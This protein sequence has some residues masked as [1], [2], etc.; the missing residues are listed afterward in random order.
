MKKTIIT[1]VVAL[2]ASV[3]VCAQDNGRTPKPGKDR[4]PAPEKM[5]EKRIKQMTRELNLTDEQQAKVREILTDEI[6]YENQ[7]RQ[8]VMKCKK[9]NAERIDQLLTPEQ[10]AKRDE[11]RKQAKKERG[12]DK[13]DCCDEGKGKPSCDEGKDPAALSK[14]DDKKC[15]ASAQKCQANQQAC[16][17][18]KADCLKADSKACQADK[19][20][21]QA[22][23][24]ACQAEKKAC[25]ADKKACQA[26][27]K[28]CKGEKADCCQA[29]KKA[30][31]GDCK[32]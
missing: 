6:N 10:K 26:E 30:C 11:T 2:F 12:K 3:A 21:C 28:D 19:K 24:K 17:A 22:D 9:Q 27:K 29:E 23:K 15:Q 25:Q 13:A 1:L 18:E 7:V 14:A 4:G 5:V 32:K 20:D 8:M 31:K 16:Q